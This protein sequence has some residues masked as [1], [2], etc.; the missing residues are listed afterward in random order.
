MT[1]FT[2]L[3][4]S[5]RAVPGNGPFRILRVSTARPHVASELTSTHS[6]VGIGIGIGVDIGIEKSR[7]HA[8]DLRVS[9]I[10]NPDFDCDPDSDSDSEASSRL[11]VTGAPT[12]V[13]SFRFQYS[14][15]GPVGTSKRPLRARVRSASISS[16]DRGLN[17]CATRTSSS[18]WPTV[19]NPS[20]TA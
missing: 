4:S 15:A 8:D 5:E 2:P 20:V 1:G 14:R 11:S 10:S 19:L 13:S 18:S 16:D 7:L 3:P 12:Q 17:C 6:T 9:V